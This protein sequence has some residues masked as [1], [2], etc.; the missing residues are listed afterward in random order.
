M[1]AVSIAKT[2]A[3]VL[4][5][6]ALLGSLPARAEIEGECSKAVG[7]FLTKNDLDNNGRAGTSRSLLVL[8]NGGHALRVDSD[9]KAA[10]MDL[11]SF[12]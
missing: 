8:T 4:A 6:A 10:T 11:R 2:T 1:N 9:Q 3:V 12:G 7:T 5:S